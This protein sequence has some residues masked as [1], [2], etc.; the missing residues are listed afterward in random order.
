MGRLSRTVFRAVDAL[1]VVEPPLR[2]W[3]LPDRFSRV[4]VETSS[5]C[6]RGCGYCP[7]SQVR[8]PDH[9]MDEALFV[10]IVDQLAEMD[11]RGRFSPHFFGE[12]LLDPRLGDLMRIVRARLPR[13]SIVVYTNGDALTASRARELLA[14]G[15]DRFVVTFEEPGESRAFAQVRRKFPVWTLRRRFL[16]RHFETD[17]RHAY[18]RGGTVRMPGRER[19]ATACQAPAVAL[20]VDAW[21]KVKLCANDYVGAHDWGDLRHERLADVWA[22]PAFVQL[23]RELL[24]GTF[25]KETC[26]VCAGLTTAPAPMTSYAPGPSR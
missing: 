20:V 23:R 8:R 18:N 2:R 6:N 21:G 9:R 7:V 17:V 10:S 12:P 26:R 5:R 11:F 13:A 1:K 15:V 3:V 14:A 19:V 25:T 22:K 16:V 24:A 4:E